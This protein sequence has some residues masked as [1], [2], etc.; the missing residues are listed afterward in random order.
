LRLLLW[1]VLAFLV[2]FVLLTA[3]QISQKLLLGKSFSQVLTELQA[4]YWRAEGRPAALQPSPKLRAAL[5]RLKH[6]ASPVAAEHVQVIPHRGYTL[7]YAEQYEQAAWAAYLLTRARL[8]SDTIGRTEDF[9]PDPAVREGSATQADYQGS[10][11]DR[12]HLVPSA[13]LRWDSTAQ[14]HSFFLSNMTPQRSA[15]NSGPWQQLERHL[16][17]LVRQRH[18]TLLV[19]SGPVFAPGGEASER[20]G[21]NKVAVPEAFYKVV[22]APTLPTIEATAYLLPHTG[23]DAGP[24]QRHLVTVDSVEQ[25]TGLDFFPGLPDAAER[26]L[27]RARHLGYWGVAPS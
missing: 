13:A 27:E 17:T 25:R 3:E 11:Y 16:R 10:G 19:I 7:G 21:P 1:L 4:G 20:I 8:A 5:K 12:G 22:L 2:P 14:S 18:D 23:A 24:P 26:K 15:F 6:L 9:R